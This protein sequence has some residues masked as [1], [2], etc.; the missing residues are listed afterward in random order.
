MK[1]NVRSATFDFVSFDERLSKKR[2]VPV[3]P[4]LTFQQFNSR[5]VTLC[6]WQ[7][8]SWM[9]YND[10]GK[11]ELDLKIRDASDRLKR[12]NIGRSRSG[13]SELKHTGLMV[14]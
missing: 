1:L 6:A 8:N 9:I 12:S 14:N 4:I 10:R 5:C 7:G 11:A 13:F 3:T 2:D